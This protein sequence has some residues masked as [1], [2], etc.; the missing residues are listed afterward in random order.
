MMIKSITNY[1]G[2]VSEDIPTLILEV[3][4]KE[5]Y[6]E[7][8]DELEI[9]TLYKEYPDVDFE[10]FEEVFEK[11]DVSD[12]E[13]EYATLDFTGAGMTI[14]FTIPDNGELDENMSRQCFEKII[15]IFEKQLY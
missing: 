11:I 7:E 15:N 8:D 10:D 14:G 9:L 1:E 13:D 3:C 2:Y 6:N 4:T 12:I 5:L